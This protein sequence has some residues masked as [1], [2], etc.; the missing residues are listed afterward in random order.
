[1]L[2]EWNKR[3]AELFNTDP[4]RVPALATLPY[5]DTA[6]MGRMS[7]DA[8]KVGRRGGRTHGAAS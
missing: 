5:A 1:M 2:A 6:H 8:A 4:N 7:E 3:E